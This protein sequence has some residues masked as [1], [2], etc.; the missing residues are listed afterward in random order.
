[1]I[2]LDRNVIIYRLSDI[3]G[4]KSSYSTFTSSLEA[5]IQPLD[6]S[7]AGMY[8]GD[9]GKMYKIYLDVDRDIVEGDQIR[10]ADGNIY[11]VEAGGINNRND[12]FMA[13][14]MGIVVK[15]INE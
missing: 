1:M 4:N 13:D 8:G 14:Y 12:G 5:T 7:K 6:N 9:H 3:G 2:L 11:Q 10:D 15:K